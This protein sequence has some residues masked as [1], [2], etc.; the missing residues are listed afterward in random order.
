[1]VGQ[2]FA[3]YRILHKLGE[4]GMGEVYKAEDTRLQRTVAIK[5]LTPHPD[6]AQ[7]LLA[8]A[9]AAA[10][11]DHPNICTIHEVGEAEGRV[12]MV[13][14]FIAGQTIKQKVA[15]RPLPLDQA[16]SVSMQALEGL[17]AAH[18]AGIVHRDIKSANL[19][20]TADGRLRITDFGLATRAGSGDSRTAG[21]LGYMSPEQ[22]RGESIDRRS[23]LWSM[24]VVLFEML[25][26]RLPFGGETAAEAGSAILNAALEPLTSLRTGIPRDLDRILSKAL[27]KDPSERYQNAA[28][29]QSDLQLAATRT[30]RPT[31]RIWIAAAAVAPVAIGAAYLAI[32]R[33]ANA[34]ASLAVLPLRDISSDKQDYFS[35][36]MTE[37]VINDLA[38]IGSIRVISRTSVMRYRD[39]AKAL[40]AIARELNVNHIV[41][42]SVLRAAENVRINAQLI[43][44]PEERSL[45]SRSYERPLGDVLA[46]HR[47]I[48]QSIAA[49]IQVRLSSAE[50]ANINAARAVNATAYEAYLRGKYHL[51]RRGTRGWQKLALQHLSDAI[52]VDPSFALAHAALAE[53]YSVG[54]GASSRREAGEKAIAAAKRAIQ[55]DPRVP[56]A[57]GALGWALMNDKWDWK[58]AGEAFDEGLRI[59]PN[60]STP[61]HFYSHYLV[62]LRR[63]HDA[64]IQMQRALLVDPFHL[65]LNAHAVWHYYMARD[66]ERAVEAGRK[67]LQ[68]EPNNQIAKVYLSRVHLFLKQ[69]ADAIRYAVP[70]SYVQAAALAMSGDHET[71]RQMIQTASSGNTVGN[72]STALIY[73]ALGELDNALDSIDRALNAGNFNCIELPLDP[74]WDPL[75]QHPRFQA[76]VRRIGL[77]S[78]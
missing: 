61:L 14:G 78:Q 74:I 4:G 73:F 58:G 23:D 13:M 48:A 2:T 50:L 41:E 44:A 52:Q 67:A 60:A 17:Q 66:Y 27:S 5:F 38:K 22:I 34:G 39:S 71:A 62:M 28:D 42:G 51:N 6:A 75:R 12:Y 30:P 54:A 3:Q 45:L 25:A 43:Y 29:F 9:R 37:A 18:E 36:G 56:D 26:G 31:R 33:K 46:L 32:P 53:L 20:V 7:L 64:E 68:M 47:E 10:A 59:N 70:G 8:E 55:L 16:L 63:F 65:A 69:F 77:P 76:A 24:G 35:E 40:P 21:S 11:L 72:Y 19:M 49:E 1:M 15:A 57:Y